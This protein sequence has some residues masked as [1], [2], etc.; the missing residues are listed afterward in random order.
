MR[1]IVVCPD[2][3]SNQVYCFPGH[4]GFRPAYTAAAIE[5]AVESALALSEEDTRAMSD[6]AVKTAAT[7]TLERERAAFLAILSNL[8]TL[9]NS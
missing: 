4:N 8:N 1:R 5:S 9:W 3:V 6:N 2:C 7:F